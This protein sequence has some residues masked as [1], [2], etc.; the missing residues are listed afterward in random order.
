V[1]TY[2]AV[3]TSANNGVVVA[4]MQITNISAVPLT[5]NLFHLAD[6]DLCGNS[7]AT[8]VATPGSDGHQSYTG[9]CTETC[10]HFA[11]GADRWEV[12]TYATDLY[13]QLEDSAITNLAN[14]AASF[15]PADVRGAFQWQDRVLRPGQVETFTV[16]LGHNVRACAYGYNVFGGSMAGS[17]G[18]PT[19]SGGNAMVGAPLTMTIGNAPAGALGILALGFGRATTTFVDLNLYVASPTNFVLPISGGGT[20]TM[21][22]N[23][24]NN[25]SY[26]GLN[27][28]GEAFVFGDAT[29]L[30]TSGLP[31]THSRGSLWVVGMY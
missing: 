23:I 12:G 17:L 2:L 1:C 29:S 14:T 27:L 25:S 8:N 30:S 4:R 13:T 31:V 28:A 21:T 9:A 6:M 7:Y 18:A 5:L 16:A 20:A 24:P 3:P 15:G 10:D 22:V 11:A 19:L 26:C